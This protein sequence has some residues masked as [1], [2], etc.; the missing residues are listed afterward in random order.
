VVLVF[1]VLIY[2]RY[3]KHRGESIVVGSDSIIAGGDY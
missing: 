3:E 1:V 2:G